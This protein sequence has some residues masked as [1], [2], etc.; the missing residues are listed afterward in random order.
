MCI[1]KESSF[2]NQATGPVNSVFKSPP[3]AVLVGIT[4]IITIFAL[5][6]GRVLLAAYFSTAKRFSA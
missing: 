5:S 6:S 2:S 1:S 4:G 3:S